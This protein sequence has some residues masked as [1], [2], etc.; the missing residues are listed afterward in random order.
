VIYWITGRSGAGKTTLAY[1]IAKQVNGIVLDGDE[2]RKHFPVGYSNK[3]RKTNIERIS[4]IAKIIEDQGKTVI[5]SCISPNRKFR[6]SM[7]KTFNEC[8]EICMPF[9]LLWK[10]TTYEE[11]LD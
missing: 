10:D 3:S 11:P 9:G 1:R 4:K 6:E 5:I 2:V 8:I 7:Q